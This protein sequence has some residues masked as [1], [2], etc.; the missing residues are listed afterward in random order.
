M[1]M[2]GLT[3]IKAL[4]AQYG[5][6]VLPSKTVIDAEL[7]YNRSHIFSWMMIPLLGAFFVLMPVYLWN[8]FRN[9]NARISFRNPFYTL[10]VAHVHVRLRRA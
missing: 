2:D 3:R 6:E 8:L 1:I 5:A 9:R 7:F 10:G 4:Q